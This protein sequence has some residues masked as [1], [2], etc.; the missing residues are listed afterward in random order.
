MAGRR[1]PGSSSWTTTTRD[2]AA[3]TRVAENLYWA[4]RYLERVEDTAR[5]VR[6]HTNLIVDLPLKVM[7]AWEPLLGVLGVMP[8]TLP[9][10][11]VSERAVIELLIS[12]QD[13]SS[14]I[15]SAVGRARE[16][17]RSCREVIPTDAWFVVNDLHLY[18]ASNHDD[19]LARRSRSRF[20]D[21][22]IA[23]HQRLIGILTS[24]MSRDA[25]FAM[26]RLGRHVER[27]DMTTRVLDVRA[28][29]LLGERPTEVEFYEDVQWTSVLRSL[30]ALQMFHRTRRTAV[31][32]REAVAFALHE[33]GFPR[34]VAY[35]LLAARD[36]I[37]ELPQSDKVLPACDEALAALGAFE[38]EGADATRLHEM[39]D[40]LQVCVGELHAK[41]AATYFRDSRA[42]S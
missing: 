10:E 31:D 13:N 2:R 16:N 15:V 3:L 30:S 41:L 29:S 9:P 42:S 38:P 19:G 11:E 35:C 22:V 34:S 17:L 6:E 7:S 8:G 4:G 21:R 1:T 24:S 25:A 20:L 14:S 12:A 40:A 32:G 33:A 18:V 28:G 37:L 23:E 27:A 5:I 26:M 39:A 36:E